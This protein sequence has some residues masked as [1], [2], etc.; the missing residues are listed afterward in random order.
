[1]TILSMI[2]AAIISLSAAAYAQLR[3]PAYTKGAAK[4]AW[5]RGLLIIVGLALGY[6]GMQTEPFGI[7]AALAFVIGFG[8]AHI[9][10]AL[11]LFLKRSRGSGRS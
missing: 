2:V 3:I 7:R 5:V 11:I 8:L 4:V 1:M 6:V 10:A 9:P